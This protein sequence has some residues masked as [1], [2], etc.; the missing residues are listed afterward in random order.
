MS[1]SSVLI[2]FRLSANFVT[3]SSAD[4]ELTFDFDGTDIRAENPRV[5]F[6]YQPHLVRCIR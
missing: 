2:C 1:T 4:R 3:Q 5:C 6:C